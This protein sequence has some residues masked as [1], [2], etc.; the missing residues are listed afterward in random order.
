MSLACCSLH[1][2]CPVCLRNRP[3]CTSVGACC[4]SNTMSTGRRAQCDGDADNS[5]IS[6]SFFFI[7]T[8]MRA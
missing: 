1:R 8:V 6:T 2:S 7:S 3:S 4:C 5:S